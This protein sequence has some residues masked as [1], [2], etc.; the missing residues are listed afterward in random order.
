MCAKRRFYIYFGILTVCQFLSSCA[1]YKPKNYVP[2]SVFKG[3]YLADVTS[4]T[5]LSDYNNICAPAPA[6][7]APSCSSG[8]QIGWFGALG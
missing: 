8:L 4:K 1:R 3:Q 2:P 6:T 7:C 5:L